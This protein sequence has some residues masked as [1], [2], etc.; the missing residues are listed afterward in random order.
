MERQEAPMCTSCNVR[1]TIEH[2]LIL[3][4]SYAQ[5]RN[6]F[7]KHLLRPGK[8]LSMK[9]LLEESDDFNLKNIIGF[10]CKIGILDKI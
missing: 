3:C 9:T 7:F 1:L 6:R 5:E 2:I 4:T 10:L 8:V